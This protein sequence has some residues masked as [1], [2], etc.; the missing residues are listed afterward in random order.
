[1][2]DRLFFDGRCPL[3]RREIALLQSLQR[4]GLVFEDIHSYCPGADDPGR[5]AMLRVL[6]LQ[7]ADGN[8]LLGLDATVRA[9]CHT[10]WGWLVRILDRA[11]VRPR[12]ERL[13]RRWAQ[14]RYRRLYGCQYCLGGEE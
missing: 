11:A 9:W 10:R 13:Y 6:H 4:G 5:E 1:M 7:T 14:R 2:P 12:A 8:W 3:C